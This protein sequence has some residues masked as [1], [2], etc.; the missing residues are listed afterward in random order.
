MHLAEVEAIKKERGDFTLDI[1]IRPNRAG[2][3]FSHLG[4]ANECAVLTDSKI[5]IPDSKLKEDKDAKAKDFLSIEIKDKDACL[6]YTARVIIN[7]KVGPSPKWLKERLEVC[8]LRPINNIVDIANY[9]MLETGQPLHAFDGEK[10]AGRKIIVRFAKDREKIVSLDEQKFDLNPNILIIADEKKPLAIAGIKGGKMPEIDKKTKVIVLESANFDQRVIRSG[11]KKLNL[12]TDASL[13]FEHGLDP[14]LT[15]SAANRAAFLIQKIAGGRITKGLVDVYPVKVLPKIIRLDLKYLRSLLG[16]NIP[17]KEIKDILG[18]LGFKLK[19]SLKSN[20][21]DVIIPTKRLDVSIQEDLIEEVGRIYGYEKIPV[22]FPIS[23]LIPPKRNLN[24]FWEEMAKDI[25]KEAGFTEVYNYS[26]FSEKEAKL[27]GYKEEELIALE[28][29]LSQE[30]KYLRI[31]LIP[32]LLKNVERNFRDFPEIRIFEL[33]KVF[34]NPKN[35]EEK[36]ML[37]GLILGDSF[38]Q[39]KGV[40]SSLFNKLGIAKVWYDEYQPTPEES[41]AVIWHP[42]KCAEIKID[43]EEV[44]FLGE[45]SP[46]IVEKSEFKGKVVLFDIDFEKLS[47]L[48]SEEQQYRPISRFPAAVRD[49]A[50]LVPLKVKVEEILN[51]IET[52]GGKIISDIDLFDIYEGRELPQGKKNLAFHIIFQSENKTLSSVEVDQI[53]NKI[54]KALEKNPDWQVRKQ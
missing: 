4:I 22:V 41:K 13:R 38:Y 37:T 29:P 49:L 34:K 16:I 54:I 51:K 35:P 24:I 30:Q 43:H 52:V 20:L 8:G 11:S 36:R 17:E 53:Q 5:Q 26:F 15:E 14:N 1:D 45:I 10:L 6:R 3:C 12:R 19:A 46:K 40:I 31:S 28:N 50:V 48:T 21:L 47:R 18:K 25:F 23:S 33:G 42:Q 39:L 9:V 44:G 32:N 7:V 27:F 2:D